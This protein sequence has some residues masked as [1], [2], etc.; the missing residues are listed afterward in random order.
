MES[1]IFVLIC[2]MWYLI[3][4]RHGKKS[5]WNFNQ[6]IARPP[7]PDDYPTHLRK[8]FPASTVKRYFDE[9]GKRLK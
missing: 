5:L 2:L 8:E 3:G 9:N 4:Y 7:H 6:P 1:Y